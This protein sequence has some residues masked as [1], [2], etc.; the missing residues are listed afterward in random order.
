ML[1][2]GQSLPV[3]RVNVS[4]FA[5][6]VVLPPA[7]A[8]SLVPGRLR[9]VLVWVHGGA[10]RA[11]DSSVIDPV[12]AEQLLAGWAVVS[13]SYD[14]S[15]LM[16]RQVRQVADAVRWVRASASEFRF[17]PAKV[18]L[19]G[20]SAGSHLASL[21]AF[22]DPVP[23]P[24]V[25]GRVAREGSRPDALVAMSG[26]Y[27]LASWK[28]SLPYGFG[29][30]Q[31][32][33]AG[34]VGCSPLAGQPGCVREVLSP[35]SPVTYVDGSDP[36][37]LVVHGDRDPV[38]PVDQADRLISRLRAAGVRTVVAVS[39]SGVPGER[40]HLLPPSVFQRSFVRFLESVVARPAR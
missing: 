17:D 7:S 25:P 38:V 6:D 26:V 19:V 33:L 11:G 39:S 4:G 24:G 14:V 27:D 12:V 15:A 29:S 5:V 28:V 22:S 1:V 36:Q 31:R 10:W 8:A 34:V 16:G 32:W 3:R 2:R 21:A 18:V 9:P 20:H 40:G 30:S 37:V 23:S 35:L 13:V